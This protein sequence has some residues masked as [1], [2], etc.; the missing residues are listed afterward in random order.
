MVSEIGA[1]N[2]DLLQVKQLR[3]YAMPFRFEGCFPMKFMATV[4]EHVI[5]PTKETF[6]EPTIRH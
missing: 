4:R 5:M 1:G 3:T 6:R 2:W